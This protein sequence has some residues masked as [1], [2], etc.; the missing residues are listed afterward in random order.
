[1]RALVRSEVTVRAPADVVWGFITDW[2]RQAEWI[3]L[4]RVEEVTQSDRVGGRF[5]A[6]TG[7]GPV[8]FWDTMTITSWESLAAGA[9]SCDVL[10]TGSVVRG[11]G[12]FSVATDRRGVTRVLWWER[13]EVP[14]GPLGA[15]AWRVVGPVMRR[16]A[17]LTLRRLA[18]R[19]E[20]SD[21]RR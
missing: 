12:G 8:G 14:G 4:T 11:D 2:P 10:H 19:V 18:Q 3:P 1:M 15:V 9:A 7:I 5:R 17:D 6:W 13:V 16:M 20:A 21:A